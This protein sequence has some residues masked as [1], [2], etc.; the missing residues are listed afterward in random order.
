MRKVIEFFGT[1]N[2]VFYE[3]FDYHFVSYRHIVSLC[4]IKVILNLSLIIYSTREH[5]ASIILTHCFIKDFR[6]P[7]TDS[8]GQF[9]QF[10]ILGTLLVRH[11]VMH[12]T[13]G[14]PR[15]KS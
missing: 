7:S 9:G 4:Q 14:D 12:S 6:G 15:K 8:V 1:I 5:N 2:T 10:E 13:Q 11:S 3:E